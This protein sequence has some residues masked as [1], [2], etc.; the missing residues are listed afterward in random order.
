MTSQTGRPYVEI[1][2]LPISIYDIELSS[3]DGKHK[4]ILERYK[5]KVTLI[6][7]VAAGC[8]N[9]PQHIPLE[10]INQK[11]KGVDDFNILAVV[12]DDFVCH[13]Y[14]EFQN[15]LVDY[16][17]KNSLSITPGQLSEQY[18]QE[19]FA[20]TYQFSELTNGRYDKHTYD[21]NFIPG[22]IK[23]QDQHPLWHYLTEA[24]AADVAEN[25]IPYH[26]E[27]IPWSMALPD[28]KTST[29]PFKRCFSPLTGNFQKFLIDRSGRKF[30]RYGNGFL[31]GQRDEN[32][33]PFPWVSERYL[34]NGRQ[35]HR[36]GLDPA[37]DN[38]PGGGWPGPSE[39]RGVEESIRRMSEDI[40]SFLA[41]QI[42]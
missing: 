39:L 2:K 18:A 9:I 41:E 42:D 32:N 37:D 27:T 24:Y 29:P 31:L 3:A 4:N 28:G 17:E 34:P 20:V 19:N 38:D 36:P 5:G 10:T 13:G 22:Q 7:N 8:G 30:K 14:P 35:D 26:D 33:E 25:G 16:I 23:V 11:Y 21:E 1:R 40:D 12:V 15:G 6:F